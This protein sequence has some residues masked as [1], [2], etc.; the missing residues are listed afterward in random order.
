MC[1]KEN[2]L[3]YI[4]ELQ[5]PQPES[6][7][8]RRR[9]TTKML[10][11][12]SIVSSPT[13]AFCAKP[14]LSSLP[15]SSFNG[16][17]IRQHSFPMTVPI[18]SAPS[19]AATRARSSS[20]VTMAWKDEQELNEIRAKT[21]EQINEEIM[22]IK[23]DLLMLRLLKS[24]RNE[25]KP[26]EFRRMRKRVCGINFFPPFFIYLWNLSFVC[27]ISLE[28]SGILVE[29][30]GFTSKFRIRIQFCFVC[31]RDIFKHRIRS[32]RSS[33]DSC[34][35]LGLFVVDVMQYLHHY[36]CLV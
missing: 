16:L 2:S 9:E 11:S 35:K 22:D 28:S 7:T 17:R 24:N 4:T 10:N 31:L 18:S 25:F 3:I 36:Y 21:T 15:K 6:K 13:T 14:L 19:P 34:K 32:K 23:G 8:Q 5:R 33:C 30:Q 29:R 26:S 1:K 20:V 27:L 12:I